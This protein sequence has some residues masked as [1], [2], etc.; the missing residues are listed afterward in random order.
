MTPEA[1]RHNQYVLNQLVGKMPSDPT[2]RKSW[3]FAQVQSAIQAHAVLSAETQ[4]KIGVPA[5]IK[6]W[7]KA[8]PDAVV[9]AGSESRTQS[10]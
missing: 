5:D 9:D 6:A 3:W 8:S 1:L 10:H 2:E 4:V 7:A